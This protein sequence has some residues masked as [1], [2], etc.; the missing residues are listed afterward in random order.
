MIMEKELELGTSFYRVY[1]GILYFDKFAGVKNGR[2]VWKES[3]VKTKRYRTSSEA[4]IE[5]RYLIEIVAP[6]LGVKVRCHSIE[7]MFVDDIPF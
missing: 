4:H 2:S 5:L 1:Y 6:A 3:F 7:S